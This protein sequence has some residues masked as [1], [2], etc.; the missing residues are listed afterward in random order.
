MSNIKKPTNLTTEI[1]ESQFKNFMY[2][3]I[4]N[5]LE[6]DG[7]ESSA[8]ELQRK[9]MIK[10]NV[11]ETKE[12][13]NR[14]RELIT[15]GLQNEIESEKD[16]EIGGPMTTE[17]TKKLRKLNYVTRFITTHKGACRVAKFSPDGKYVATGS[18]DNSIKLLEVEKMHTHHLMKSEVE[19]YA[20]ARP[21]V[22]TF[23][24]HTNEINDICFHPKNPCVLSCS[25]DQTIKLFDFTK[26]S[27]KRSYKY[28]QEYE[29]VKTIDIHP[30][31]DY[32]VAGTDNNIIRTY[33]LNNLQCFTSTNDQDHHFSSINQVRYSTDG[34][35]FISGGQDGAIKIWDVVSGKCVNTLPN[36][37]S[38]EIHS[39]QFTKNSKYFLSGGH[40]K[41][42]KLWELSTGRV[43]MTYEPK[44][45]LK[46]K[47]IVQTT[48]NYNEDIV[49]SSDSTDVTLFNTRT[50]ELITKLGGHNKV[51]RWVTCSPTEQAIVSCS[52]DQRARFWVEKSS[53]A[54]E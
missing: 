6:Y 38:G 44:N 42:S 17:T 35:L 28:I 33:D 48:F 5:Q 19:D 31:G 20:S 43:V 7:F 37:H 26:A 8:N 27:A 40:D 41:K 23:Y 52:D 30:S 39:V 9:L 47:D 21:V 22:R 25:K 11:V 50:G 4:I 24:D 54:S 3:M 34:K 36:A 12:S 15:K 45:S 10:K 18:S 46:T 32:L 14:L 51:I 29:N 49:V 16:L 1:K 2:Q 13:Q 53:I